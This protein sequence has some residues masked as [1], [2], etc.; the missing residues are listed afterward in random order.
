LPQYSKV[1]TFSKVFILLLRGV[2]LVCILRT[3]KT[4]QR[5]IKVYD[6]SHKRAAKL[7]TRF[8]ISMTAIV[9]LALVE[10]E[11]KK[12]LTLPARDPRSKKM[13]ARR[14]LGK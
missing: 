7:S 9:E 13:N 1:D 6:S 3:M 11:K 5:T 2:R 8:G 4:N 12:E 10:L 14:V